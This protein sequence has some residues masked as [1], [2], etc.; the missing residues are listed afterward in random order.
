MRVPQCPTVCFLVTVAAAQLSVSV[1]NNLPGNTPTYAYV[2]AQSRDHQI[3]LLQSDHTWYY[4]HVET[5]P[6]VPLDELA[7]IAIPLAAGGARTTITI[8]SEFTSGRIWCSSGTLAFYVVLNNNG[9]AVLVEPSVTNATDPN[10]AV[11]WGFAELSYTKEAG[12]FVNLSYVDFVG[13]ALGISLESQDGRIQEV[14]G[15]PATAMADLCDRLQRQARSSGYP[16]DQLC[17]TDSDGRIRRVLSPSSQIRR[18]P[19]A[20]HDYYSAYVDEVWSTYSQ[21]FLTVNPQTLASNITCIVHGDTLRCSGDDRGFRK[22]TAADIFTCDSGPFAI[23]ATDNDAHVAVVP[24][25]CAA[26]QRATLLLAGGDLQPSLDPSFYYTA[27]PNNFYSHFVHE[28]EL[29][30]KGYAFPYDDVGPLGADQ[31]GVIASQTPRLL[32][33]TVGGRSQ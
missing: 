9:E 29:D 32:T 20:F 26:F 15:F 33:L 18:N 8:P 30:G 25:L 19:S 1:V 27:S 13:L 28:L 5:I 10:H 11:D 22:P 7:S 17:V 3:V 6:S 2:T 16:W 21:R 24:R 14:S 12:L 31:S 23:D 4:P